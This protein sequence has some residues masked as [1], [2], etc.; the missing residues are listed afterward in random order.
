MNQKSWQNGQKNLLFSTVEPNQDLPAFETLKQL[1][2]E[3]IHRRAT[4][5]HFDPKPNGVDIR[6]RIDG[7]LLPYLQESIEQFE[8]YKRLIKLHSHLNI[9]EKRQPQ[10]GGFLLE[11]DSHRC[12]IRASFV[13]TIFGEK[14]AIRFLPTEE[15]FHRCEELGFLPEQ[16]LWIEQTVSSREGSIIISGP[17]GSGKSTTLHALLGLLP[18][19]KLHII[20][21]EDPVEIQDE[22]INQVQVQED[23]GLHYEVYLKK[24]MRLDPDVLL[25][26]EIRDKETARIACEAALT[27]HFFLTTIH[28]KTT[29]DILLRLLEM[30]I[31][32]YLIST[33]LSVLIS[34]R[35][36][37]KNCPHCAEKISLN[38]PYLQKNGIE[39]EIRGKG[40]S[41]CHHTGYLGRQGVF[42]VAR[43]TPTTK[44]KIANFSLNPDLDSL[45]QS[46]LQDISITM[47][48]ALLD[49]IRKGVTNWEEVLLQIDDLPFMNH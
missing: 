37:R 36:V 20:S 48:N 27:G 13:S 24:F 42:E 26:G 39:Y 10:E 45:K 4:D 5:L 25:L 11:H 16:I 21:I 22:E 30:N 17:T 41:T 33:S 43:L 6:I 12:D 38:H 44:K 19:K 46:F 23:I 28:T 47:E 31:E 2:W 49:L 14:C 3:A 32:P 1:L 40:C 18:K 9:A 34:E 7:Q 35:L 29:F 15:K 8:L